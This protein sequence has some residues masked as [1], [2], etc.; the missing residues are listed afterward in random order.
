MGSKE[1]EAYLNSE[2]VN[3]EDFIRE[4]LKVQGVNRTIL[5]K[6]ILGVEPNHIIQEMFMGYKQRKQR[7]QLYSEDNT[8]PTTLI[9]M[10]YELGDRCNFET[11][12][13]SFVSRYIKNESKLEG[14]HSPAEIE[15]LREM[16]EYIHSDDIDYMFNVFTLKELHEKLYSKTEYPY[17]GGNFRRS[18]AYIKGFPSDLVSYPYIFRELDKLDPE[19]LYLK[20]IAP[21]V[22]DS[23][24]AEFLL[25]YLDRCVVLGCELI[26]IHPFADGNGRSVRG[27]I[28]KL[29]EDAGLPPVYITVPEKEEYHEAMGKAI[30][31]G[32][33]SVIKNFYRYKICDSIVELD[34]NRRIRNANES[35]SGGS[36]I[37]KGTA[38]EKVDDLKRK[39]VE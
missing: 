36:T 32:D 17:F 30:G 34:I 20:E 35:T 23:Q 31:E 8:I 28:N 21:F 10:Y 11:L 29:L 6:I 9:S 33:Y 18:D 25:E 37:E 1:I 5:A 24:D 39:D 13:N 27:F 16:Y 38:K 22:K 2:D 26:R 12:K 14:V 19:V 3:L 7:K 15:G 4:L